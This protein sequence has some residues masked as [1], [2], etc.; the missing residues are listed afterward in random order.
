VKRPILFDAA[1][2]GGGP[3]GTTAARCLARLGHRVCILQRRRYDVRDVIR[4]ETLSP[5]T[6]HLIQHHHP[7]SWQSIRKHLVSCCV[8]Q[9]WSR[10][11]GNSSHLP[12][13][14][15]TLIDRRL[16][17]P[18]LLKSAKAAGVMLRQIAAPFSL[19]RDVDGN[20]ILPVKSAGGR[21][22]RSRFLVDA[23]GRHSFIPAE[24]VN[25][26]PRTLGVVALVSGTQ[27]PARSTHLATF[28]EGWLWA[29]RGDKGDAYF[30]LF[31][32]PDTARDW[33]RGFTE[34]RFLE[35]VR[36][37]CPGGFSIKLSSQI[38]VREATAS[39]RCPVIHEQL[40]RVGDA[41]FAP[42]PLSSQGLAHALVSAGQAAIVINTLL[43]RKHDAAVAEN[44]FQ[45][46]HDETLRNHKA[47]CAEFY[48]RQD[49]FETPFWRERQRTLSHSSPFIRTGAES[50]VGS[51]K[52]L[53][54]L[55]GLS[56]DV[57]W[58]D[59][60][61]IV[62]DFVEKRP[63]LRHPSLPRPVAFI[64]GKP[65]A[66]LLAEFLPPMT[67]VTLLQRW[68]AKAHMSPSIANRVL[69]FFLRQGILVP[70]S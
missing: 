2:I 11:D 50:I 14:N 20:W 10:R 16:L 43:V 9:R 17:D 33:P 8:S 66:D 61:V 65:V 51:S 5:G 46:R 62:G 21:S 54:T 27:V 44:F 63:V 68:M 25:H 34:T 57:Y 67:G 35:L 32:S 4:W 39:E 1:I 31:I 69:G 41:A 6:I 29:A 53:S 40:L 38:T 48:R 37:S 24:R 59:S 18:L 45:S 13:H 15:A 42:D 56:A 19:A 47:T 52:L 60:A 22:W 36:E 23:A 70:S 3:A 49:K 26:S 64:E 58:K 28:A 12:S 55:L 7:E 30:M